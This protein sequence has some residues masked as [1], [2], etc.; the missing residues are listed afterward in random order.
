MI[1]N[2]SIVEEVND[3]NLFLRKI[4]KDD[5]EFVFRS[6]NDNNL[7]AYLSLGPLKSI[8]HSKRLIKSYL[9]YWD[10]SI[11]FNYIIELYE[12]D[13]VKIGSISLWNVNWKHH[14]AQI[15]IWLVPFFW[16]K[17]FGEKSINL[18]NRRN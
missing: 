3:G 10:N 8:E 11:Q 18:I 7:I 15:G 1:K 17:G 6:L 16:S 14:R 4:S 12:E 5:A 13:K 2:L 9:K